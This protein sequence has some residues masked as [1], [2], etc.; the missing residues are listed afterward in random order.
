MFHYPLIFLS[1]VALRVSCLGHVEF[2]KLHNMRLQIPKVSASNADLKICPDLMVEKFTI[3]A[4]CS[5]SAMNMI[6]HT[7]DDA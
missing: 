7:D 4:F 5:F 2:L 3:V 1:S 6:N